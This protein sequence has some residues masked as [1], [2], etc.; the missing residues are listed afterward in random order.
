MLQLQNST[1]YN[2]HGSACKV[3]ARGHHYCVIRL[4]L[5]SYHEIP[6]YLVC[7]PQLRIHQTVE[8]IAGISYVFS[9]SKGPFS[10]LLEK[11][12]GIANST[13]FANVKAF[14]HA[15]LG[16]FQLLDLIITKLKIHMTCYKNSMPLI[17]SFHYIIQT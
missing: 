4:V 2:V 16:G 17:I 7:K 15:G 13:G 12:V 1:F 3:T 11:V 10:F 9:I 14:F 8:R 6:M 5:D